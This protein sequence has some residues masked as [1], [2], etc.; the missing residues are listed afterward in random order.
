MRRTKI[1]CTMGPAVDNDQV[2][3]ELM[4]RGMNCARM[5]FSHD[6]HEIQKGRM[7]RI[8]RIREEL[9][10]PLPILLDTKGPEIRVADFVNKKEVLVEGQTFTLDA[11]QNTLGDNTRVGLTY[12]GLA[13]Y[14]VPG[15][16]ILIDDGKIGME[17]TEIVDDR[18][19]CVVQNPGTISNHKSINVPGLDI[20]MP[21]LNDRDKSD[22]LFGIQEE[23]DYI[24]ASFVRSVDDVRQLRHFL[25][26]NNGADIK[27]ISKIENMQG[28]KNMEEIIALSDGIM[29]ARGDLGVEVPFQNL[30]SIQKTMIDKCTQAG[31]IVVTATQMLES[32]T[33]SPRPTRAEVSDVANAI[34]DGTT[35]IML[36]GETAAGDYPC[37]AVQ[38]MAEIAEATE[39]SMKRKKG[40]NGVSL[41]KN[42]RDTICKAACEAADYMDAKAIVT[43]TRTGTTAEFI[44]GFRPNCPIIA[45]TVNERGMRQ[46]N[47]EWGVVPVQAKEQPSIDKLLEYAKQRALDTC[48]VRRGDRVVIVTGSGVSESNISDTIRICTL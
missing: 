10:M 13:K 47:L 44:S 27:I 41:E 26:D 17:V 34:Y 33:T 8:K 36:S 29:V 25:E 7:D 19:V 6:S 11:D 2:L 38:T 14:M 32:M 23:V 21:Y 35:A 3:R 4:K 48:L 22:I 20:P 16:T 9:G 12:S 46:L 37:E 18:I 30:P 1:I 45:E 39:Q 31:K 40:L 43:V 24:A 28:V 5:N 15:A 42:I